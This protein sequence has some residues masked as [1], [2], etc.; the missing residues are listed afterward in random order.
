MYPCAFFSRKLS[1]AGRNYDY[2]NKEQLSIKDALQEWR[3][4]LEGS[5]HPFQVITD[6]KNIDYIKNAKR[7]NPHHALFNHVFRV[8]GIPEDIVSDRGSQFTYWVW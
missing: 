7:L 2:G 1:P 3:H 8:H 4:W 6:H 5:T